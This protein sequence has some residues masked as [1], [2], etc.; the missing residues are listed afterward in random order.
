M[1]CSAA[2]KCTFTKNERQARG[3]AIP[4]SGTNNCVENKGDITLSAIATTH[5]GTTLK[6]SCMLKCATGSYRT[7][8]AFAL[9]CAPKSSDQEKGGLNSEAIACERAL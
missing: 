8:G 1:L 6:K 4:D 2:Q 3:L 9:E 7:S 5:K